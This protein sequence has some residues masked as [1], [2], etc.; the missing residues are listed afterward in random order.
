MQRFR[1]VYI[2]TK[3]RNDLQPPKT[4]YNH[5]EKFRNHLKNIYNHPQTIEYHLKQAMNV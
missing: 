4:A 5:L 3:R 1:V 2:V